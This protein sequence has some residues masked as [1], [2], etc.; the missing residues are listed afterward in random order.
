MKK[1]L[2]FF[3]L[4]LSFHY[5]FCQFEKLQS[6]FEN[7]FK[8]GFK[9]GYCYGNQTV[10]CFTP[11]V[12]MTPM[13][14]MN[15]SKENYKDGYNRGFQLGLDLKRVASG[16]GTTS[17]SGIPYSSVPNYKFNDY[18]PQVPVDAYRNAALSRQR[19]YDANVEW[20][21][22]RLDHVKE[23]NT[24][25][26]IKLNPTYY[27]AVNDEIKKYLNSFTGKSIDWSLQSNINQ[28][29]SMLFEKERQICQEYLR[30]MEVANS[31]TI[32]LN[33][34][35]YKNSNVSQI[36]TKRIR[37]TTEGSHVFYLQNNLIDTLTDEDNVYQVITDKNDD[38]IL[39]IYQKENKSYYW[40]DAT[41]YYNQGIGNL[42]RLNYLSTTEAAG[43]LTPNGLIILDKGETVKATKK[44]DNY[45]KT[46]QGNYS[47]FSIFKNKN[48]DKRYF[49]PEQLFE[50]AN[51]NIAIYYQ[52]FP[53]FSK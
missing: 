7:G 47:M 53:L 23:L 44:S 21:Q 18:I 41:E 22:N 48:M 37:T 8:I 14:N 1:L 4:F 11:P 12:P 16:G 20:M 27:D 36:V 32:D 46:S 29:K 38:G 9:E 28:V 50:D 17:P 49:V 25:L 40:L 24:T 19:I 39:V 34:N 35:L 6:P 15:E 51:V 26:L 3:C 52:P 2:F 43:I 42:L 5:S 30:L 45:F 31:I 33:E 13:L 10:D